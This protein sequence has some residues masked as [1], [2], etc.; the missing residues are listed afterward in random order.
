MRFKR[1][2]FHP[3]PIARTKRRIMNAEKAIQR[4]RDDIPLLLELV[5]FKTADERLDHIDAVQLRYWQAIRYSDSRMWLKFRRR[6]RSL[7]DGMQRAFLDYWNTHTM[8][9]GEACYACDTL[10]QFFK[11]DDWIKEDIELIRKKA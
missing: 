5:R 3:S 9:P 4:E 2:P 8:I 1:F 10:T 6:L 11:R 7:P